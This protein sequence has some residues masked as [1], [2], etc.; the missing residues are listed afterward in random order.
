MQLNVLVI[1][2]LDFVLKKNKKNI[3]KEKMTTNNTHDQNNLL[4][5]FDL[6]KFMCSF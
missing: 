5:Q 3:I 1:N 2:G 4:N 6:N